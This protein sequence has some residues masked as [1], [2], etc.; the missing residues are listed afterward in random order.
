[1]I[2]VLVERKVLGEKVRQYE[3]IARSVHHGAMARDGYLAGEALRD[4][5]DPLHYM[6]ISTWKDLDGWKHWERSETRREYVRE[7]TPTL[8]GPERIT[9]LEHLG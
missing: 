5:S 3:G 2:R 4:A 1:M 7:L 9:V 6:T 8:Q